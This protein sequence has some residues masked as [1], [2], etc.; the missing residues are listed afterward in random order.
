MYT[1]NLANGNFQFPKR[2]VL[3]S[4]IPLVVLNPHLNN[5]TTYRFLGKF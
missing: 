3:N 2:H 4:S 5:S 1:C